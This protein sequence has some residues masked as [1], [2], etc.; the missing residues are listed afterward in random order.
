[1]TA[2]LRT[3][4]RSSGLKARYN[5]QMDVLAHGLWGTIFFGRTKWTTAA[6]AFLVG[7]APDLLAFGPF[8][9]LHGSFMGLNFPPYVYQS[10]N[11]THS[12]VVW[13]TL[14]AVLWY[15]RG[16][17][18]WVF[19]AWALHIFCDIPLHEI[20]FFPTPYLWPFPTPLVNGFR[21]AQPAIMI[22]NYSALVIT[23]SILGFRWQRDRTKRRS[24]NKSIGASS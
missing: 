18:P 10:Y 1:M 2:L 22:P 13:G 11:V 15:L 24:E 19:G 17:F 7:M 16:S 21:W 4:A 14:A 5:R 23:Y 3:C 6:L 20:S 12:L 8:L 9:L